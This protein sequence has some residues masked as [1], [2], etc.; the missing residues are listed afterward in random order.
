MRLLLFLLLQATLLGHLVGQKQSSKLDAMIQQGVKD[1]NIP[2]LA[3]VVVHKGEVVFQKTYGVKDVGSGESVDNNTLFNMGST[4]KAI[5]AISIGMLVDQGK[6]QWD[7]KVRD[8][9]PWFRLSDPYVTADARVKDLLTHNLGS[10]NADLLWLLDSMSTRETLEKFQ[11]SERNY[12]LRGGFVYQNLMYAIAGEL[13]EAVSGQHWTVFVQK[14]VFE[15]L[16]MNRTQAKSADIFEAGN[17][18]IPYH[19]DPDEGL[20]K[21]RHTLDDQIGAAGMIW[22]SAA[23]IS[24]YLRF[25]VSGGVFNGDTL[26][27]PVTFSYLFEPHSFVT[28]SGFYPTQQLTNPNWT[29]YG[30]GWFQHD[31]R[32]SKLDF[33]T[34][35]ITGLVAM[36]GIMHDKDLAVYVFSNLDHAELRHSI[37]YKAIDLYAFDDNTRDWHKE[38]FELYSGLKERAKEATKKRDEARVANT[39]PTLNLDEYIGNYNHKMYGTAV[40]SIDK[41]KLKLVFNNHLTHS[42][43]HWNYDTFIT[44]KEPD[45]RWESLVKFNVGSTGKIEELNVLGETFTRTE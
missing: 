35:S 34:G 2:G 42:L 39:N 5:V 18:A 31:Y 14:N 4:T 23:D 36:A 11:L 45:W 40:V 37:L 6:V 29:T 41:G 20:V 8:H 19:D 30:L 28:K 13:I 27:T 16:E 15:P 25:L 32:G 38:I 10:G 17:Y 9:L 26:I 43:S 33:H 7:D 3:A 1:W 22:S 21:V 24:N 44:N 12:P